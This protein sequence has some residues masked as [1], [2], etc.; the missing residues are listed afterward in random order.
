MALPLK[1]IPRFFRFLAP[2]RKGEQE[3]ADQYLGKKA[4]IQTLDDLSQAADLDDL[5]DMDRNKVAVLHKKHGYDIMGT[6]GKGD[7]DHIAC[8][9]MTINAGGS[10][11]LE[12]LLGVIVGAAGLW[13]VG[14][15]LKGGSAEADA[16]ASAEL[17]FYVKNADGTYTQVNIPALPGDAKTLNP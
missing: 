12:L 3:A 15:K 2:F 6:T 5:R 16:K 10:R 13:F 9:D 4:K 14:D 11:L 17:S 7:R 8:D 1:W